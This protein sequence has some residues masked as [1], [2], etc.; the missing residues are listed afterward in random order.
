[1]AAEPTTGEGDVD[2]RVLFGRGH[3]PPREAWT[4]VAAEIGAP[5]TV[6][7]HR[8]SRTRRGAWFGRSLRRAVAA[9]IDLAPALVREEAER[10]SLFVGGAMLFALGAFAYFALGGTFHPLQLLVISLPALWAA[11]GWR[12]QPAGAAGA[13]LFAFIA[14]AAAASFEVAAGHHPTLGS[15]VATEITGRVHAVEGL[16][17][18][19]NRLTLGIISTARPRLRHAPEEVRITVRSGAGEVHAGDV[20]RVRARLLPPSGPVRPGGYDFS[21]HAWFDGLGA[22]GFAL[23]NVEPVPGGAE[24]GLAGLLAAS[25]NDLRVRIDRRISEVLQEPTAA[26]ASALTVGHGAAIPD[27]E[28]EALRASGLAHVLSISGLHMA[29]AAG[30]V[31]GALR[32]LAA[33]FPTLAARRP[34]RKWAAAAGLVAAAAYLVISGGAVATQRSFMMLAIILVALLADRTALTMRNLAL[35]MI[36]V[37]LVA[38]HEVAGPSFQMSFAATAALIAAY[39]AHSRWQKSRWATREDR[40]SGGLGRLSASFVGGVLATTLIAGTA[41][42]IFALWH[43]QRLAPFAPLGNLLAAPVIAFVVMPAA[44]L[45]LLLM[46]LGLDAPFLH[47]MGYGI[48]AM[49]GVARFVADLSPPDRTGLVSGGAILLLTLALCLFAAL[50]TALRWVALPIALLGIGII[51]SGEQPVGFVLDDGR[52]VGLGTGDGGLAA[53]RARLS[54]FVGGQWMAALAADRLIGPIKA[55][56]TDPPHNPDGRGGVSGATNGS[57]AMTGSETG[58]WSG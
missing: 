28:R 56:G 35:A 13:L 3:R 46:P 1:M 58:R 36:L 40:P 17:N 29:L 34:T 41:T 8:S 33:F 32:L 47:L 49:L 24:P 7:F 55:R 15:P 38:P 45:S 10:G 50:Q 22:I 19:G 18:G 57:A 5:D 37:V 30:V 42:T 16:A 9:T 48:D 14:G 11:H 4:S 21:F 6:A 54:D 27:E 31:I 52:T 53:N 25:V 26:V 39:R 51:G 20:V 43:F 23:G 2:E 12:G 44:V